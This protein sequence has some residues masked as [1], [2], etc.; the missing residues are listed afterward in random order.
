MVPHTGFEP[1][2]SALRGRCP[3]PLDE[4]GAVRPGP[5]HRAEKPARISASRPADGQ[6][7]AAR[8][9]QP[10]ALQERRIASATCGSS[11]R[12]GPGRSASGRR[13]AGSPRP[14]T[15]PGAR[16]SA[17]GTYRSRPA[18][19]TSRG[20]SRTPSRSTDTPCIIC[21]RARRTQRPSGRAGAGRAARRRA[22]GPVFALELLGQRLPADSSPGRRRPGR[23][24]RRAGARGPRR[25]RPAAPGEIRT[26]PS[27]RVRSAALSASR[28]PSPWPTT[29]RRR[30][31]PL[32]RRDDVLDVRVEVEVA[33][34]AVCDQKWLRRLSGVA[35]P[36]AAGEVA[37]VA[38]PDPRAAELAVDEQTGL[39][40]DRRSGSHDSMYRPRSAIRSRPC[41]SAARGRST[42]AGGVG[43][44]SPVAVVGH[45]VSPLEWVERRGRSGPSGRSR[46]T[47]GA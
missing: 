39:R 27:G 23:R 10:V 16:L 5:L 4:C 43:A 7:S 42:A 1:V 2:I 47:S 20:T 29:T 32:D 35:L 36:A 21:R 40:R 26:R 28:P 11:A 45:S 34:S 22:S 44:R 41:G 13:T 6:S 38:L 24:A 31:E 33:G 9:L 30:T 25:S 19:M 15:R 12:R 3:G 37:E 18:P 14:A 46:S 17:S 8:T